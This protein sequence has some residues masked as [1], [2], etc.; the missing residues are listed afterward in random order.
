MRTTRGPPARRRHLPP[1]RR[2]V[3]RPAAVPRRLDARQPRASCSPRA[4]GNVTIANAV[5]NGVA[6]DKLLYTYVPDL[7]RYYLAEEPI[8]K[9]VDTWRLEEPGA[10]EEV[11]DRLDE[12]V[13]KP[14]DGSGG[15]GLVVGPDASPRRARRRCARGCSPTRAA[16]SR[17]RSCMLSTDPDARRGR[18]AAAARRPAPVRGQRRRRR[19]G[20]ARRAHPRRAA[21]GAARRQLHRRAAARRTPGCVGGA[22]PRRTSSTAS[23]SRGLA[24]LVADQA[25]PSTAAIPI[26][27]DATARV[28]ASSPQR[29]AARSQPSSR[30]AAAAAG[31]GAVTPC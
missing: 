18:D 25:T 9:N 19:L 8:L 15:K 27:Y 11:L 24:G 5:G 3:P 28:R 14:V 12:L 21:R 6:D 30:T 17:S 13:V 10:L 2:R 23:G 22:A 16:G 26:I 20:A 31:R 7:I 4:L 1:G 29:A